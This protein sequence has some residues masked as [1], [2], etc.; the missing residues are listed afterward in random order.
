M[1]IMRSLEGE[2]WRLPGTSVKPREVVST[3]NHG[4]G[5]NTGSEENTLHGLITQEP[6]SQRHAERSLPAELLTEV[7]LTELTEVPLDD[8]NDVL[9]CPGFTQ[10]LTSTILSVN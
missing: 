6:L 1:I 8:V 3:V 10:A 7:D 5:V 4:V 2:V 9:H